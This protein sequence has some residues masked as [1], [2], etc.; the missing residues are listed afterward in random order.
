M[1]STLRSPRSVA[2]HPAPRREDPRRFA[3]RVKRWSFGLTVAAFGLAW[4]LVSQNVVGASNAAPPAGSAPAGTP[5]RA[6][7]PSA[8]FFG[9]SAAQPRPILGNGGSGPPVVSGGTS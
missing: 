9:G 8:D 5:G 1:S 7:V 3:S 6:A 4:G 2:A